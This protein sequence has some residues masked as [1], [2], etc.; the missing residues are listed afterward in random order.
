MTRRK[1]S[2]KIG[3]I[4]TRKQDARPEKPDS[5]RTKK[6]PKGQKSG[7]RNSQL[8]KTEPTQTSASPVK[9]NKKLGSKK[10]IPLVVDKK[11][12]KQTE[13]TVPKEHKQPTITLTKA[14]EPVLTPEQELLSIE[15]DPTLIELVERVEAGEV[16]TGKDAKYFN[17]YINRHEELMA[18]LGL[19]EE[20]V[21]VDV[22]VDEHAEQDKMLNANQWDD[23]LD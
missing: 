11:D 8:L 5:G 3:Q 1:K 15:Q 23:L 7:S 20:D 6:T 12:N 14:N 19:D 16:L 9:G 18:E 2:R 17:K 4:G 13:T 21:D 10:P 22:D